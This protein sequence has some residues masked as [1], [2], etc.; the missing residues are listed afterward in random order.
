MIFRAQELVSE[1]PSLGGG[2]EGVWGLRG[3][4]NNKQQQQQQQ[5][6]TTSKTGLQTRG[7]ASA[8]R[9]GGAFKKRENGFKMETD[10]KRNAGA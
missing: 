3:I 1:S 4:T 5:Q 9:V 10:T 2:L 7:A 6:Q 8:P